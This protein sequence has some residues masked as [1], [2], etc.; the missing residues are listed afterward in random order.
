MEEVG[1][2]ENIDSVFH[3]KNMNN[4]LWC[5]CVSLIVLFYVN[6]TS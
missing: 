5:V 3:M 2:D 1:H 6:L 4:E